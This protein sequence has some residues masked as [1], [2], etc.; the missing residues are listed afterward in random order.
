MRP[1]EQEAQEAARRAAYDYIVDCYE[2]ADGERRALLTT[3]IAVV[4]ANGGTLELDETTVAEV[5]AG[6]WGLESYSTDGRIILELRQEEDPNMPQGAPDG[7]REPPEPLRP[8]EDPSE[9]AEARPEPPTQAGEEDEDTPEARA[10]RYLERRL[11][12]AKPVSQQQVRRQAVARLRPGIDD[13]PGDA[14]WLDLGEPQPEKRHSS[15]EYSN[16][17]ESVRHAPRG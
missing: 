6:G 4:L 12:A 14:Q 17:D 16:V 8:V 3:L 9:T 2:S 5:L 7:P 1:I 13:K 10:E 11:S 15:G